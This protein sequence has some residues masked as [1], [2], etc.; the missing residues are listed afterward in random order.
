[1]RV[2]VY[3][4][5]CVGGFAEDIKGEGSVA[6][7]LDID[8]KHMDAAVDFLLFSP[9]DVGVLCVDV[10]EEC[11]YVVLVNGYEGVVGLTEPEED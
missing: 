11:V 2:E 6:V 3:V 5:V 1:M 10:S 9:F 7:A 4:L 8:V